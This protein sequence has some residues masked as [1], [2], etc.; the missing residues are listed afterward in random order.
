VIR[1][2]ADRRYGR[3]AKQ[4][5]ESGTWGTWSNVGRACL[6]LT[7]NGRT[8]YGYLLTRR[9]DGSL[10]LNGDRYELAASSAASAA[11]TSISAI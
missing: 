4:T 6:M 5:E 3:G 8:T 11:E 7:P 2:G 9:G 1:L 10:A